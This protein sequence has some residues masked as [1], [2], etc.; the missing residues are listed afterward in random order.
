[1]SKHCENKNTCR[2]WISISQQVKSLV[3]MMN[4]W[5]C[6]GSWWL[7]MCVWRSQ[8]DRSTSFQNKTQAKHWLGA[9]GI[10]H[11]LRLVFF[12]VFVRLIA[13]IYVQV[14]HL[15][16]RLY[17]CDTITYTRFSCW[18]N[19]RL[20]MELHRMICA[21]KR[22]TIAN[23]RQAKE[24]GL[25]WSNSR[26]DICISY[27]RHN[28]RQMSDW[29]SFFAS[30]NPISSSEKRHGTIVTHHMSISCYLAFPQWKTFHW[31]HHFW[32]VHIVTMAF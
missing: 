20:E 10:G 23:D 22:N 5:L 24:S 32:M 19:T 2:I 12:F 27:Y 28:L 30:V 14:D 6:I 21:L 29:A 15:L 16:C 7:C 11:N 9:A 26:K 1:M 13:F 25:G 18:S 4:M 31:V 17:H 3:R 8:F